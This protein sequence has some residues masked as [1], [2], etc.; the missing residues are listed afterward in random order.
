MRPATAL[1]PDSSS[2]SAADLASVAR[3]LDAVLGM[4]GSIEDVHGVSPV[5]EA[6]LFHAAGSSAD[7]LY[8]VQQRIEIDG[9]LELE[10]FQRAWDTVIA[11]HPALRSTFAW[12]HAGRPVQVVCRKVGVDVDL[13]DLADDPA[14]S[15]VV[16]AAFVADR[17]F[18][19]DLEVPPLMRITLY[20]VGPDRH[21]LLWSQHHLLQ[22]G[23]SSSVVLNEVFTAYEAHVAGDDPPL[24]PARPFR[25]YIDWLADNTSTDTE[26][27][28]REHLAGFTEPTRITNTQ[29]ASGDGYTRRF[30]TMT[31]AT[32]SRLHE[33]AREHRITLNTV[34]VGALAIVLGRYSGRADVAFGTVAAGRPPT[35][36]G[37]ESMVGMFINT[38]A[39]RIEIDPAATPAEWL[40]RVQSRQA[41]LFDHEHSALPD[42][43]SWS[44]LRPGTS[45]T[46]V[47][48]AYWNFGGAGTSPAGSVTY[49]TVDGYG[50]TSFP[51]SITVEGSDPLRISVDFDTTDIDAATA[52]RFLEHYARILASIEASPER[53]IAS[54][55][56]LTDGERAA[57]DALNTTA[58]DVPFASVLEAFRF[59][60][61][62]TPEAIAATSGVRSLTYA[63]LDRQSDRLAR[64][65]RALATGP[66]G[67]TGIYLH[68]SLE[69]LVAVLGTWK[70]GASYVPIDRHHPPGRIGIVLADGGCDV[71]VTSE[72]L[73]E[74][75]PPLDL[76]TVELPLDPAVEPGTHL[77][78]TPG[79]GLAYVMF[80]SG[81][82]G[83]PK[84]VMVRHDSLINYV[85]WAAQSYGGGDPTTFAFYS[86]VGF[87]LT[88]TSLFVPLVTG[89][90]IV[91]YP[92]RDARDLA[93]ID[94]FADDA[95]DVVKLT[96]SH[97]AV[98][99]PARL[100]T[101]RI[102]T[103]IVGG[104]DLTV[105]QASAVHEASDGRLRIFN[106]YGP[107]EAT[108]GC[109]I[110]RYDPERDT[111]G[112]VPIGTPAANTHIAVLDVG[113]SPVPVG[114]TGELY[115]GGRGLA[116]G[117][118]D[119]PDLTAQHFVPD[120]ASPGAVLYRTGDL[121]R[122]KAGGRLEYAGRSDE[123]VKVRGYRVEP[124]EIEAVLAEHAAVSGAAVAV[125]EPRPGDARLVAYYVAAPD[126]VPN[127]TVLRR[128][129]RDRLPAY[130][131]PGHLV[132]I[133]ALP[134]SDNGKLDR[135]ALPD[136]LG[137]SASSARYIAPRNG[138]EQLVADLAADLIGVDEVSMEDNFFE[139]GGHSILA[140]QLIARLHA[141][142]GTRISPRVLLLNTLEQAAALL[143]AVQT[144]VEIPVPPGARPDQSLSASAYFFGPEDEELF[145]IRFTPTGAVVRNHAVLL[146]PPV[147]WEYMRTHRALRGLARRLALDGFPVLR[148]DY[149]AT[150]DSLGTSGRGSVARWV[151]D[152]VTAAEEL[153][154]STGAERLTVV[155]MRLG[156]SLAVGAVREGAVADDLLL[157][158]PIVR[159]VDH[160][161][162]LQRMHHEML[163]NRNNGPV[164]SDLIGDE[165][166]G[167][168][169]P[170]P[171]REE[172]TALDLTVRGWPAVATTIVA[173]QARLD[174]TAVERH[175]E[176]A[177]ELAVVADVAAWDDLD[178]AQGA[179]LPATIPTFIV[180]KLRGDA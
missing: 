92:D 71:V 144:E 51:L 136:T 47:L 79:G 74:A 170:M 163:L 96:P 129:L 111:A 124:G 115:V 100:A 153:R 8:I 171:L 116:S 146:C 113:M 157:W 44:E 91:V 42:V 151:D 64:H 149:F 56:M 89:G 13:V 172:I 126:A 147:G 103:L 65:L 178:S 161:A 134:L 37:V 68:R 7:D 21:V 87:D 38:L 57:L 76:P 75:L 43:Q 36:P 35:L 27:F 39:L 31:S 101:E 6:M 166:L 61:T 106:E 15:A 88:V 83:R 164:P 24:P 154:E 137:E 110:H 179:L 5:Q 90:T 95:V 120:P 46:D 85:W 155:G 119:R 109:M 135:S 19:F 66:V 3:R 177:V 118:L 58:V 121:V 67:R 140:M 160:L 168:P 125:R 102:R 40:P 63:E 82:T 180:E 54:L 16:D 26:A 55:A 93:V 41:S 165:M 45:L 148:F 28:W 176:G 139:L 108:V 175:A 72:G 152:V 2:I 78:D 23:W 150:G 62:R 98:L 1:G 73:G 60:A 107:T 131:V 130:M 84:G 77:A 52:E 169:Y 141:A 128:H 18:R 53:P 105:Q 138:A 9:P 80:T 81:S 49:R 11:R 97:L 133:E 174:Y 17:A 86:S 142:T 132:E 162:D 59:Q 143:P 50:R 173:S 127:L 70:A 30:H 48:F 94:V 4:S 20:R 69:F 32:T 14:A 29:V 34:L 123:Q 159:G 99:D 117:Y 114:A 10:P 112:S 167:F 104:E 25:D 22:D 156:G 12:Q 122:W 158:D 33:F 145:G